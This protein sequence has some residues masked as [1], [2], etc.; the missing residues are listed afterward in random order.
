MP[1]GKGQWLSPEILSMF[2]FHHMR[3]LSHQVRIVFIR[4]RRAW[5]QIETR[6]FDNHKLFQ[7]L[8][9]ISFNKISIYFFLANTPERNQDLQN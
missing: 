6:G 2:L 8:V 7:E 9:K 3:S 4:I 5:I 1:F